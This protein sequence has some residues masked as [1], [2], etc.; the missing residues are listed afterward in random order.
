MISSTMPPTFP[1]PAAFLPV[2]NATAKGSIEDD[3]PLGCECA[4]PALQIERW[5]HEQAAQPIQQ[6]Y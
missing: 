2:G 3:V 6:F 5:G 1:R 4:N